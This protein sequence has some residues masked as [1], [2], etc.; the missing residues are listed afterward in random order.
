MYQFGVR[1]SY[2]PGSMEV[3]FAQQ[4]LAKACNSERNL[5]RQFGAEGAKRIQLRLAQLEAATT[6][7]HL[8]ELPGRCHELTGELKGVLSLDLHGPYRLLFA[9][10]ADPPPTKPDGG[11]D[12]K[13][14]DGVTVI[15]IVDTHDH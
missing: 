8:R 4:K 6:L 1:L 12:W 13:V 15:D 10:S 5:V 11:L 14:V 7:E 2:G 9:P 3:G